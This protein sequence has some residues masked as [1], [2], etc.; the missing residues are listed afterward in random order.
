MNDVIT[1][2]K[3][4]RALSKWGDGVGTASAFLMMRCQACPASAL[5]RHSINNSRKK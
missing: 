1:P 2:H 3:E 4:T 5:Y